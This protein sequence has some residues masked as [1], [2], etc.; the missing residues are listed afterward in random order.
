M[1]ATGSLSNTYG[2]LFCNSAFFAIS[3]Y[4][5]TFKSIASDNRKDAVGG[6]FAAFFAIS[7]LTFVVP[8]LPALCAITFSLA[9]IA[10]LISTAAYIACLPVTLLVDAVTGDVPG[11]QP[12]I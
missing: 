9:S 5:R 1:S 7:A 8:V 12:V 4:T 10:M 2:T 3:P 6:A 11:Y